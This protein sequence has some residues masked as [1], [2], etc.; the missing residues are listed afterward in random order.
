MV[1]K[2]FNT[3]HLAI[4]EKSVYEP[5]AAKPLRFAQMAET[6]T[7]ALKAYPGTVE[8]GIDI[9][10]DKHHDTV[11]HYRAILAE[12]RS[13]GAPDLAM[14]TVALGLYGVY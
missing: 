1:E 6:M 11:E 12:L 13:S 10:L 7:M 14:L 3:Q 2:S 4:S 8:T 5:A 9:W